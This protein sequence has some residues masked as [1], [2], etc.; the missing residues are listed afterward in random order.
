MGA[1]L[2]V[3]LDFGQ[4]CHLRQSE[5]TPRGSARGMARGRVPNLVFHLVEL[6]EPAAHALRAVRGVAIVLAFQLSPF[7]LNSFE[8]R[9]LSAERDCHPP[10]GVGFR[11]RVRVRIRVRVRGIAILPISRSSPVHRAGPAPSCASF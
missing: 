3:A 5:P 7:G 4:I 1:K 9:R 2:A 8:E 11:V 10:M 6:A